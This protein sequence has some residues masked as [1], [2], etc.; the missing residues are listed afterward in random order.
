[1]MLD[2]QY[3]PLGSDRYRDYLRDIRV[4]G[5]H[6]VGLVD[7]LLDLARIEAGRIELSFA[8]LGLNDLVAECVALMQ[9]LAARQ[10]VVVRTSFSPSLRP[11]LADARSLRQ[12]TMNVIANAI[13]YTEAGGQVIVS[14]AE[15][16]RGGVALR[17]RDTGIGMTLDEIDTALQPFRRPGTTQLR[18]GARHRARPAAHPRAGRGQSRRPAPHQPEGRGQ[19]WSRSCSRPPASSTCEN[20]F[21]GTGRRPIFRPS[22]HRGVGHAG[23]PRPVR[24]RRRGRPRRAGG[25][26]GEP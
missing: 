16:D 19:P 2:E 14:T 5:E 8:G 25:G 18:G 26:A 20:D 12:A 15:T 3:G 1:M 10:R 24:P 21:P 6:V 7:D 23:P 22:R 17:V 4:S 13:T 9:P 11:V